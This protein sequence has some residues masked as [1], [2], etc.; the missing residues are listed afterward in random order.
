MQHEQRKQ[1]PRRP[2]KAKGS[3]TN[4]ASSLASAVAKG[5]G[6][7]GDDAAADAADAAD[8]DG[9]NEL[10]G[11]PVRKRGRG[12]RG[13]AKNKNARVVSAWKERGDA[14]VIIHTN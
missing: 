9:G 3:V 6:S 4:L 14:K 8:A 5:C 7:G 13:G 1:G 10:A 2:K 11:A 12:K